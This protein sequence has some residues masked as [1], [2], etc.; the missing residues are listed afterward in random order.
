[1]D[2]GK[3]WG[4]PPDDFSV[5]LAEVALPSVLSPELPPNNHFSYSLKS[6]ANLPR[7]LLEE[8]VFIPNEREGGGSQPG[9]GKDA[10]KTEEMLQN[11]VVV[12]RQGLSLAAVVLTVVRKSPA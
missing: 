6:F 12:P 9:K 10:P 11:A 4:G 3:K 1:M 2:H 7:R 8:L 5:P